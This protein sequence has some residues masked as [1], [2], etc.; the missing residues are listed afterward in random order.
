M[1][2]G[3]GAPGSEGGEVVT[4]TKEKIVVTRENAIRAMTEVVKEA[5]VDHVYKQHI[6]AGCSY[7][8]EGQPDC[9]VGRA[10]HKL[11]VS[12][13]TLEA[14]DEDFGAFYSVVSTHLPEELDITAEA[15]RVLSLAQECQDRGH[16]WGVALDTAKGRQR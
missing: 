5:G 6:G 4:E 1:Q 16:T 10:L 7:V 3:R 14:M 8:Y 13:E 11:G 15:W 2:L 12:I 9:L